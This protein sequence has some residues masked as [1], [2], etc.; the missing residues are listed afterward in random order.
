M[1]KNTFMQILG[2]IL[3]FVAAYLSTLDIWWIYLIC[4]ILLGISVWLVLGFYDNQ[5]P[6][7]HYLDSDCW[8]NK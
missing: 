8:L 7:Y 1:K 5:G 2:G 4:G 6:S 3:F